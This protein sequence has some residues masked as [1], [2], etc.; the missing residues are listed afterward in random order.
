ML[1]LT[2]GALLGFDFPINASSADIGARLHYI[3]LKRSAEEISVAVLLLLL[4]L[5]IVA[6]DF[7]ACHPEQG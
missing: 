1:S 5:V 4:L 2:V 3:L 6:L 7:V